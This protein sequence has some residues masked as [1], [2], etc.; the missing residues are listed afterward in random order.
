MNKLQLLLIVSL[1]LVA[2]PALTATDS[3]ETE[4]TE[5]ALRAVEDRWSRAED[6]GDVRYLELLLAPEYRSIGAN[7]ESTTRAK[8]IERAARVKDATARA[9]AHKTSQAFMKA[10]PTELTV[11]VHGALG[12]V[13]FFNPQGGP[14]HAVRGTDV[15]VYEGHRWRAVYAF[16]N[17]V[18]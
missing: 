10:H 4:P 14:D 15:F 17:S 5:A 9:E 16:H 8:L 11:V 3:D 6:D 1:L 2:S 13:S 12:I 18:P 7:G